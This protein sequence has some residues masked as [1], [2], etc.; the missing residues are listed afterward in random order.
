MKKTADVLLRRARQWDEDALAQI[1]DTFAPAIYRYVYRRTGHQNTAEEITAETFHRFLVAL[2]HGS[3]PTEYLSA[4]LY[5]VA[6]N[7]IVDFYRRQPPQEPESLDNVE[8]SLAEPDQGAAHVER[9]MQVEQAR[10]ALRQ[11]TPLQQQ[12]ITLRYLEELSNEDI[13]LIVERTE[14]AVKA[15]QH[16][17]LDSLRRILEGWNEA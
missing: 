8:E 11:L 6:H 4:W 5:R 17:A 13:A 12:I 2:K 9:Q 15:L 14:G 16:R 3:G 7:L 1:Y 10:A